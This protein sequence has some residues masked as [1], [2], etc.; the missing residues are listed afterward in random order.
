MNA[1]AKVQPRSIMFHPHVHGALSQSLPLLAAVYIVEVIC[2]GW[3]IGFTDV[4]GQ[5]A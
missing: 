5:W 1:S 3:Q 4:N 2:D